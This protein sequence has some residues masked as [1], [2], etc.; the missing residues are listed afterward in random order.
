MTTSRATSPI[1][2]GGFPS[3]RP[4]ASQPLDA[5]LDTLRQ[6]RDASG[7]TPMTR[8]SVEE[9]RARIVAGHR[10][11]SAGPEVAKVEELAVA[12]NADCA[13]VPVRVYT[14]DAEVAATL[15]YLHGGGWFTG[16]LDYA[17]ELCRFLAQDAGLRVVSVDYRLAPEH[18]YPLPLNDAEAALAWAAAEFPDVP[19]GISGDSAGGNLA[20]A[21]LL[22]AR[23]GGPAVAFQVLVYPVTDSDFDR[24]SYRACEHGFPLGRADLEH[25]FAHYAPDPAVR[26]GVEVS[27][28]RADLSGMPPALVVV[29]GHDPLHD[30][31]VAHAARLQDAGVPVTL[32]DHP[33]LCH[34]FLRFTGA[35]PASTA[36]R[37]DLVGLVARL[38]RGDATAADRELDD[39]HCSDLSLTRRRFLE[40]DTR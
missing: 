4:A 3:V 33:T 37:D 26:V 19:L 35:S 39:Y 38:A 28:V 17:D 24:D 10:L 32:V 13:A 14:P 27:P 16:D 2:T 15:V 5:G 40:G 21:T 9:N 23:D 31:G 18:P 1:T 29:A 25:C 12:A 30:E 34:G 6:G 7:A 20:A 36:A 8:A 22:R 11:C